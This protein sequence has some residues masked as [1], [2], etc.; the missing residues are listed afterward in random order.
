MRQNTDKMSSSETAMRLRLT[1]LKWPKRLWLDVV[2]RFTSTAPVQI[3]LNNKVAEVAGNSTVLQAARK[4]GLKIPYNCR[5][6]I[7]GACEATINGETKKSCYTLVKPNMWVV[8]K[9]AGM[10]HWRQ[11][12]SDE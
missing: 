2:Q 9:S 5:A 10:S 6:G 3:Q 4:H 1:L 12:M 8:E 7:C 11:N